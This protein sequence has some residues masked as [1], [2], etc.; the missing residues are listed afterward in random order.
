MQ[1]PLREENTDGGEGGGDGPKALDEAAVAKLIDDRLKAYGKGLDK[2]LKPLEGLPAAIEALTS[3]IPEPKDDD[4]SDVDAGDDDEGGDGKPTKDKGDGLTPQ[5]RARIR[6]AEQ[7]A[8]KA[9]EAREADRKEAAERAAKME[10]KDRRAQL[11]SA[12]ANAGLEFREKGASLALG[13]LI[14]LTKRADPDD[15]DS[16]VVMGDEEQPIADFVKEWLTEGDGKVYVK[17]DGGGSGHKPGAKGGS[18]DF[19]LDS[20]VPGQATDE[21]RAQLRAAMRKAAGL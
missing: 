18:K 11:E 1:G 21:Q 5:A 4:A 8:Q 2:K 16:P 6:K 10:A 7:A 3:R 20:F 19:D 14:G 9:T 13:N 17:L 15:F 12:I